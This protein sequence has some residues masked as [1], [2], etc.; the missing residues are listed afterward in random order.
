MSDKLVSRATKDLMDKNNPNRVV[1]TFESQEESSS[2]Y[3]S[4]TESPTG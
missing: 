1:N 4:E 2:D 3:D